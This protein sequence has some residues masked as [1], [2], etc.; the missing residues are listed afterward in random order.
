MQKQIKEEQKQ[1]IKKLFIRHNSLSVKCYKATKDLK[2]TGLSFT[3]VTH[4]LCEIN[5]ELIIPELQP[6]KRLL[7]LH[8]V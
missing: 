5:M 1:I 3:I 6:Q 7:T 8:S 2:V 4:R